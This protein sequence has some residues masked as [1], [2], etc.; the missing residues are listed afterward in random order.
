MALI[1]RQGLAA[2]IMAGP[3]PGS[4]A[5]VLAE[6]Q[7]PKLREAQSPPRDL[8]LALVDLFIGDRAEEQ[9]G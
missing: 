6:A 3:M 2:W 4:R 7:L 8:V 5:A 9:N 1:E